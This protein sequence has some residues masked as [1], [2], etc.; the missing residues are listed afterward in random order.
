MKFSLSSRLHVHARNL[1]STGAVL[2][3]MALGS[4]ALAQSVANGKTLYDQSFCSACHG[5]NPGANLNSIRNGANNPA[6]LLAA[7]ASQDA[8]YQGMFQVCGSFSQA[9]AADVAAF[10]GSS[11]AAAP[12]A[13]DDGG[14]CSLVNSKGAAFDPVLLSL[15]AG[16]LVVLRRRRR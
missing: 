3:L 10:I 7:C 14:G 6:V 12:A 11:V 15:L 2:A 16:A 13:Q 4:P 1:C 9:Q 5:D 8:R